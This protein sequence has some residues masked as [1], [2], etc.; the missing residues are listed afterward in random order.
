MPG[1]ILTPHISGG[2]PHYHERAARLF[3]ENLR[4]YLAG[5]ALHNLFETQRGY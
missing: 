2:S 3:A 5:A 1:V 4:N